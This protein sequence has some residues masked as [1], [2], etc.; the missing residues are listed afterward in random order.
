MNKIKIWFLNYFT[1]AELC[2][3]RGVKMDCQG[4]HHLVC[5]KCKETYFCE[6]GNSAHDGKVDDE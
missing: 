5:P 3:D 1:D 2:H 4:Y 6:Y